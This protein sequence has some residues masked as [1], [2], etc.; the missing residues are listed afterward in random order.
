[1]NYSDQGNLAAVWFHIDPEPGIRLEGARVFSLPKSPIVIH[2]NLLGRTE[3]QHFR[4]PDE[5]EFIL[6]AREAGWETM[7]MDLRATGYLA[8]APDRVG[9]APDHNSAEWGLWIGRPLLGQ[10]V[11]DVRRMIDTLPG[12]G[13]RDFI[14]IGEGPAGLVALCA[15]ATDRRITK[16]AAVG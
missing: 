10:W 8:P 13:N 5:K 14:L 3:E 11:Y 16:V 4:Y 1:L 9:R 2:L 12:A 6:T 15:A 7:H